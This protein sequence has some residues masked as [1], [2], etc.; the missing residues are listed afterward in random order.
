MAG[1]F[2]EGSWEKFVGVDEL[3]KKIVGHEMDLGRKIL[4]KEVESIYDCLY[5]LSNSNSN[6]YSLIRTLLA[7]CVCEIPF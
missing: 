5:S 2:K 7:Y 6:K 4:D 3:R 1:K